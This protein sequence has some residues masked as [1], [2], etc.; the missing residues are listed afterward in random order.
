MARRGQ[1][2]LKALLWFLR[3][4][5]LGCSAV[6]LGIF[7]YFLAMLANHS[8]PITSYLKAVEGISGVGV[9]YTAL[10]VLLLCCLGGFGFFALCAVVLDTAFMGGFA[11][12]V[13]YNRDAA[14]SCSGR[15]TTVFGTGAADAHPDRDSGG[16]ALPSLG[17]ACKLQTAVLAVSVIAIV[18]FFFSI[19][20]EI[21][22]W[23]RHKANKYVGPGPENNYGKGKRGWFGGRKDKRESV[24]L[25]S[26]PDL[27]AQQTEGSAQ[28]LY[29]QEQGTVPVADG[30]GYGYDGKSG[31]Y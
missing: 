15:V 4:I 18:F 1:L 13:W 20:V 2:G 5:Q 17:T 8:L 3:L 23:R 29:A 21:A 22:L 7:S 25:P 19:V 12:I 11:Y 30:P 26:Y 6:V 31:H 9:L 24:M 14:S 27:S 16:M 10:A 28:P